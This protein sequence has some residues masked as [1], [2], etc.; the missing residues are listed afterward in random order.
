MHVSKNIAALLAAAIV[1]AAA[2][3]SG[4]DLT[5]PDPLAP[6]APSFD[7]G[8]TGSGSRIEEQ[9]GGWFGTGNRTDSTTT[10]VAGIGTAGSGN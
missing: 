6:A 2:A 8:W 7:G 1:S 3:C 10:A 5:V 9:G 4:T